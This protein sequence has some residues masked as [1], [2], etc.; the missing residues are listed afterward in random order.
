MPPEAFVRLIHEVA[1]SEV[2]RA[3]AEMPFRPL[4]PF[5]DPGLPVTIAWPE[6]DRLLPYEYYGKAWREAAP[7]AKWQAVPGVGHV[8]TYDEPELIAEQITA[9]TCR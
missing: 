6:N 5:P 4:K 9:V 7:F 2:T 1:D 8:P 3:I